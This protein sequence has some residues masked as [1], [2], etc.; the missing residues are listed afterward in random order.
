MSRGQKPSPPSPCRTAWGQLPTANAPRPPVVRYTPAAQRMWSTAM[1]GLAMAGLLNSP[2]LLAAVV[3]VL[4]SP[5]PA[6]DEK[7]Y[8]KHS[9]AVR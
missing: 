8:T 2:F 4:R 6:S 9:V 1:L 3:L 5:R 7:A